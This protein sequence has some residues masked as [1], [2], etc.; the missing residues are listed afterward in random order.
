[1]KLRLASLLGIAAILL[2]TV[3]AAYRNTYGTTVPEDSPLYHNRVGAEP[4]TGPVTF[5]GT[6]VDA[7]CHNRW[8]DN[9]ASQPAPLKQS[10]PAETPQEEAF[11]NTQRTQTGFAGKDVE[12][13]PPGVTAFGITVD[14]QTLDQEQSE[15]LPH[16]V[17]DL[18][19]RQRDNSCGITGDTTAFAVLTDKGQLVD[20]DEGGN[21]WAWQAVQSTAGGR[22]MLEG[23]GAAVKPRVTVKGQLWADT[24]V[25]ESLS[26]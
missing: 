22:D 11:E 10:A 3:A 19:S 8:Q 26:L 7:G 20:L 23:K 13:Q 2:V 12:P 17:P 15:V 5:T 25:V 1:M 14:K 21:T 18:Y 9:L 16:Q 6:L 24:L 4:P